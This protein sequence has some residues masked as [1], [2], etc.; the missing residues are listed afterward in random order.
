VDRMMERIPHVVWQQRNDGYRLYTGIYSILCLLSA[1]LAFFRVFQS[2]GAVA[3]QKSFHQCVWR[4]LR[5]LIVPSH[6]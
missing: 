1:S 5:S 6:T 4:A 2:L 3:V